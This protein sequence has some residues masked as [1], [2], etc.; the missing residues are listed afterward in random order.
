MKPLQSCMYVFIRYQMDTS[1]ETSSSHYHLIAELIMQ[2]CYLSTKNG[3][4][5]KQ[6][7]L[8]F[9]VKHMQKLSFTFVSS[10][11]CCS[12][13]SSFSNNI[14]SCRLLC[15]FSSSAS[16]TQGHDLFVSHMNLLRLS[17]VPLTYSVRFDE[18]NKNGEEHR[19]WHRFWTL[20]K[21]LYHILKRILETKTN[22]H[23]SV[24][25]SN[26]N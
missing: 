6:E 12:S 10:S 15:S 16:W 5:P 8:V 4:S 19:W 20:S 9:S 21:K 7:C 2:W 18:A 25:T 24:V 26:S 1:I 14:C 23:C 3:N 11:S 17:E 13:C 22:P